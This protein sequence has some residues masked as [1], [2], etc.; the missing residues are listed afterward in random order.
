[1]ALQQAGKQV[2]CW[3]LVPLRTSRAVWW[4]IR[5]VPLW[6]EELQAF[7]LH[8]LSVVTKGCLDTLAQQVLGRRS[9]RIFGKKLMGGRCMQVGHEK[10]RPQKCPERGFKNPNLSNHLPIIHLST[11]PLFIHP[12][13]HAPTLPSFHPSSP[14]VP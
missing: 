8:L 3:D 12:P 11:H 7:V 4:T 9:H 14:G 10:L 2:D 1:M 13:M 6:D 5:I